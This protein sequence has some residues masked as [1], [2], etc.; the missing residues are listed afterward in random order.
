MLGEKK[1]I[2]IGENRVFVMDSI[3]YIDKEICN[4]D[5]VVCGSHGGVSAGK[6]ALKYSAPKAVIFND[7]GMGKENAGIVALD[8]MEERSVAAATVSHNTA[9]IGDGLDTWENG[10]VSHVN[11]TAFSNGGR[12]GMTVKDFCAELLKR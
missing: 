8:M 12:A 11:K 2:K 3:S 10:V 5:I 4:Q 6:D 1:L 9:R 7:A